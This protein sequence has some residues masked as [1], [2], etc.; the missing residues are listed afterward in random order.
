MKAKTLWCAAVLGLAMVIAAPAAANEWNQKT[1]FTFNGPVE[2]PGQTLP[3]GTYVFRLLDSPSTRNVVQVFNQEETKLIA[4]F[5]SVSAE[6][7]RSAD[8]PLVN[9]AERPAKQAPAI[10]YWFYP[11]RLIGHE[12]V[13]PREQATR[14]ARESN[15]PVLATDTVAADQDGMQSARIS[16]V[17]PKGAE[18]EYQTADRSSMNTP[19]TVTSSDASDDGSNPQQAEGVAMERESAP[20]A[21]RSNAQS[22]AQSGQSVNPNQDA[23]GRTTAGQNQMTA[24]PSQLPQT[25]SADPMLLLLAVS[26]FLGLSAIGAF[27]RF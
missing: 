9:F 15:K 10:Q 16:R 14:I 2:L 8:V 25:A 27:N 3:E 13:Y 5:F 22:G 21:V 20:A 18:S 17:D 24:R 1:I 4:T 23:G 11:G 19:H 26:S 6:R 7:N 12:F